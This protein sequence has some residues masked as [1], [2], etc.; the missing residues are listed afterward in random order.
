MTVVLGAHRWS[1][2][3][4]SRVSYI[5][6]NVYV[7]PDYKDNEFHDDIGLVQ[8]KKTVDFTSNSIRNVFPIHWLTHRLL[9]RISPISLDDLSNS[10]HV[11][12]TV[13]VAGWGYFTNG[14]V[15]IGNQAIVTTSFISY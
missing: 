10:M 1:A 7:H 9:G 14:K 13:S 3:E 12:R 8:L 2:N 4:S 11:N 5:S 6:K 15:I